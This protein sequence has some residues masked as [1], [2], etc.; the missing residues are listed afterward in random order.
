MLKIAAVGFVLFYLLPIGLAGALW[1]T[2]DAPRDWRAADRGSAGLLPPAEVHPGAVV[3]VFAART[4]RW[5]GIF[6][7]HSWIVLKEAG[8]ARYERYDYT[9]W[10]EPIRVNGFEAD[11]RWF[12]QVPELV[13]AADDEA[14]ARLIPGI[15]AAIRSY[16][17]RQLGDYAAWPGPNSNTF[18]ASVLAALPATDAVLPPTAIGKDYP[19]DGRWIARTPSGTGIRV[20]LGGYL[21]L[22]A[23]WVEGLELNILGA[24]AGLDLRRPALKLPAIGRVGMA[25]VDG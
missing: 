22:T 18:V 8:A 24:V 20:T 2:G 23:G 4:V 14:A 1:L 13:Y 25:A 6:A 16:G 15:R 7:V 19:V 3:R 9:A 5:R 10:G 21:G 12:G 11:G 17:P